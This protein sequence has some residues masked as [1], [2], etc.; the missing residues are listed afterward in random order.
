MVYYYPIRLLS[1]SHHAA[2]RGFLSMEV[3]GL[4]SATAVSI[5]LIL[6]FYTNVEIVHLQ[7]GLVC[8][9]LFTGFAILTGIFIY[10]TNELTMYAC[11]I[12][13]SISAST[14]FL[15]AGYCTNA[16]EG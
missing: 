3:L 8:L 14:F 6:K 4:I 1:T 15:A 10:G 12:L 16:E 9:C 2:F 5:L 11:Y 7:I 13:S